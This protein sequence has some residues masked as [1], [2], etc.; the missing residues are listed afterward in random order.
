MLGAVLSTVGKCRVFSDGLFLNCLGLRNLMLTIAVIPH[1]CS[2]FMP[3]SK[4]C[5]PTK[6]FGVIIDLLNVGVPKIIL[7]VWSVIR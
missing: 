2:L 3:R 1:F 5:P 6:R 4:N 7:Q